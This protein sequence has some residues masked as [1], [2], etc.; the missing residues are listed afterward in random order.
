MSEHT[1]M[2]R[3]ERTEEGFVE[4]K[5]SREHTWHFDGGAMVAASASPANV[6]APFSNAANVDPEEAYVAAISSCHMLWFLYF[7]S[8]AGFQVDRYEDRAM[9][10]MTPN[11]KGVKWVSEIALRPSI[12]WSGVKRPSAAEVER[13]HHEAHEHCFLANSVKT[14]I[15]VESR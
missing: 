1:A 3:W 8:R 4:G 12:D 14:M 9:G 13:L 11:E 2:V 6:P 15:Q 10:K 5:Y 7:A